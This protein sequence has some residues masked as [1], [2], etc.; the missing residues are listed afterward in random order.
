VAAPAPDPFA[1]LSPVEIRRLVRV[2]NEPQIYACYEEA[3]GSNPRLQGI[4]T[5]RWRVEHGVVVAAAAIQTPG[6]H[7]DL[8]A[9]AVSALST[10]RYPSDF[11]D[12]P[13]S[14]DW[15]L[16]PA[17]RTSALALA[18]IDTLAHCLHDLP[19]EEQP[20]P[21]I[22]S[23]ALSVVEGVTREAHWVRPFGAEAYESCVL[24]DVRGWM[25]P[26]WGTGNQQIEITVTAE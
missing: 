17:K 25:F 7:Q 3:L 4:L 9:C 14:Q 23:L 26:P 24:T 11:D 16:S 22:G 18:R 13:P 20:T 12:T 15:E 21:G 6:D 2:R 19:P 1:G 5:L 10:W 8:R